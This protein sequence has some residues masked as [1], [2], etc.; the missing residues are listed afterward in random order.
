MTERRYRW[1]LVA[2]TT[3][4]WAWAAFVLWTNR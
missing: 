3:S 2:L 1:M 4:G